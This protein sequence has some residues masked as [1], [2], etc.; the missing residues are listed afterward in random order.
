MMLNPFK[1]MPPEI[2]LACLCFGFALG[3]GI[4]MVAFHLA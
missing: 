4:S 3:A 2:A 1:G